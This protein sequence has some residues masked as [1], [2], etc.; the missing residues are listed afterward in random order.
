MSQSSSNRNFFEELSEIIKKYDVV[1]YH[2]RYDPVPRYAPL[3]EVKRDNF[4]AYQVIK[5]DGNDRRAIAWNLTKPE[6]ERLLKLAHDKLTRISDPNTNGT[7][8]FKIERYEV[9]LSV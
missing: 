1:P 6:A 8:Y 4:E 9:K 7:A 3:K 5:H 2:L